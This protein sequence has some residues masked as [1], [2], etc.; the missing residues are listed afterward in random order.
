MGAPSRRLFCPKGT[1]LIGGRQGS[2]LTTPRNSRLPLH[3]P[4][5]SPIPQKSLKRIKTWFTPVTRWSPPERLAMSKACRRLSGGC[6]TS[7]Y[8]HER[9][10]LPTLIPLM[11]HQVGYSNE[12][13]V[14][15][16]T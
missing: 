15:G 9:Q 11:R 13:D 16:I 8:H 4:Q 14:S 3:Q 1:L 10:T 7:P 5:D 2:T 6:F 12:N